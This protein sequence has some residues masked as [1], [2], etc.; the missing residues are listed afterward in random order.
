MPGIE[1]NKGEA[2]AVIRE[3]RCGYDPNNGRA[4]SEGDI[5]RNEVVLEALNH[6]VWALEKANEEL[7]HVHRPR[8]AWNRWTQQ[9]ENTL[10]AN[11]LGQASITEIARLLGRSHA[12]IRSRLELL[13]LVEN[14][15]ETEENS[16]PTSLADIIQV[17]N[18][19][20]FQDDNISHYLSD[21]ELE[22][23]LKKCKIND[24]KEI[25]RDIVKYNSQVQLILQNSSYSGYEL[26]LEIEKYFSIAAEFSIVMEDRSIVIDQSICD[27]LISK[28]ELLGASFIDDKIK[29]EPILF[30]R[31]KKEVR[32]LLELR[33]GLPTGRARQQDEAL[34]ILDRN[35]PTCL[36]PGCE[37]KMTIRG[38]NDNFFWGCRTFPSCW[39][40]RQLSRSERDQIP[41]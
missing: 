39:G 9:D 41:D 33:E 8:N 3:L 19:V 24:E 10:T 32:S 1:L 30:K 31:I 25:Q 26:A 2:L 16:E 12:G 5:F 6:A 37:S 14:Q 17:N 15:Y 36:R 23:I 7:G 13:G 40:T 18:S 20:C 21:D 29:D 22:E 11:Y 38:K 28:L 35:P 27:E 4:L 34:R